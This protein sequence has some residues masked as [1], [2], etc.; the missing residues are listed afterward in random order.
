MQQQAPADDHVELPERLSTE[1]VDADP[2][3]R[4]R[5]AQQA[6]GDPERGVRVAA[7]DVLQIA[8][9]GLPIVRLPVPEPVLGDVCGKN[10]GGAPALELEGEE[11]ICGPDVEAALSA[12]IG[13][14]QAPD[15]GAQ[16]EHP[17]R[18]QSGRYLNR[19]VPA[20]DL[21]DRSGGLTR[22]GGAGL[23]RS[24]RRGDRSM[25]SVAHELIYGVVSD[26]V[27]RFELREPIVEFGSM[28]VEPDQPGDLRPL[29]AGKTFIGTDL[30]PGPGVDQIEDLT[31]LSFADGEVGTA[32]CLDTLEHCADPIAAARE[33][34]RVINPDGG[35]CLIS[36]VMLMPVHAYPSDY[37]RFTP[38]GF[39]L[40]LADFDDVDVAGWGDPTIPFWV[41]GLAARGRTLGLS[42][43]ELPTLATEQ[44][45][46]DRG[47]AQFRLGPFLYSLKQLGL[48]VGGQLPRV[49]T[50][51]ASLRR[52]RR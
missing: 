41:F 9:P 2:L 42:L 34:R 15:D 25:C 52:A 18:Y 7:D 39:R 3:E 44:D 23:K 16:V 47:T 29:F 40:L 14:G 20:P 17:G 5:G 26:V 21:C 50:E 19:V 10:L 6:M 33:L 28:Q 49:L 45:D 32:L 37:W 11:A 13:P 22:L 36:S 46:Y 43:A 48:E 51:R 27:G 1:V 35:L 12:N 8:K 24:H 38:E 30:R 4:N 31:R